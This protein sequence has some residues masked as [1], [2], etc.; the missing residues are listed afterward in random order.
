MTVLLWLYPRDWRRR[1]GAEV[2]ALL[3]QLRCRGRVGLALDLLRGAADAHLH[4]QWPRR[5]R[6]RWLAAALGVLVAALAS[7]AIAVTLGAVRAAP[8]LAGVV[9]VAVL[10]C[11]VTLVLRRLVDRRPP[12]WTDPPDGAPVSARP[13]PPSPEPLLV[14]GRRAS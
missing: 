8:V 7:L 6:R 10:G 12:P 4:P 11:A 9:A 2:E 5:P 1:Y 14:R 3:R 13:A